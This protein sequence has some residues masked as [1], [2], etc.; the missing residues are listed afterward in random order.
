MDDSAA[1]RG[2]A[3]ISIG[4]GECPSA[5]ATGQ[6]D[7]HLGGGRAVHDVPAKSSGVTDFEEGR[8][9]RSRHAIGDRSIAVDH[10]GAVVLIGDG[11]LS[12]EVEGAARHAES[13][14]IIID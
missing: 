5:G 1:H 9:G 8:P 14:S 7:G 2:G 11:I 12:V 13:T 4:A 3:A 6:G 10:R